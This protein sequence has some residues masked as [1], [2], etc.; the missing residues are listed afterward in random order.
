MLKVLVGV[1]LPNALMTGL[2]CFPRKQGLDFR[3]GLGT[4]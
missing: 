2:F 4:K 1:P 3:A